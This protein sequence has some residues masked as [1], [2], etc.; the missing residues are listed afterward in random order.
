M[1]DVKA[2]KI[3]GNKRLIGLGIVMVLLLAAFFVFRSYSA[4]S[5]SVAVE[6]KRPLVSGVETAILQAG[7]ISDYS[8]TSG[9]VKAKTISVLSAKIMG[10]VTDVRVR[11]GERVSAGQLLLSID[12]EDIYRQME[13]AAH[14]K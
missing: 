5:V 2:V 14:Q 10:V 1:K 11:Q 4:K 9:T 7:E 12:A 3:T 13:S 8:E 6:P